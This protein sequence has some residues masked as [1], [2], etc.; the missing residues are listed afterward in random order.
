MAARRRNLVTAVRSSTRNM[1]WLAESDRAAVDLAI[2]YAEAIEERAAN[3]TDD[4]AQKALGWLG[5]HLLNTL[6]SIG[7]TPADRAALGVEAEAKG[8]LAEI[9]ALRSVQ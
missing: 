5:P 3:G 9:R 8:R 6:K 4:Q 7:G 1:T 2:R